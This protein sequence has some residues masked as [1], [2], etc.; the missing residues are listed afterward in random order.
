MLDSEFAYAFY[1]TERPRHAVSTATG[2]ASMAEARVQTSSLQ[3]LASTALKIVVIF[4]AIRSNYSQTS[5]VR[6]FFAF[7]L[8]PND[9]INNYF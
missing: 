8:T 1:Y 2:I 3:S 7:Y 5:R 4:S 9:R 6:Y